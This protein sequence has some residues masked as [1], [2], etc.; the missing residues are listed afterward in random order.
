MSRTSLIFLLSTAALLPLRMA[1]AQGVAL[2]PLPGEEGPVTPTEAF[3]ILPGPGEIPPESLVSPEDTVVEPPPATQDLDQLPDIQPLGMPSD[4]E[5]MPEMPQVPGLVLPKQPAAATGRNL[6][7][8]APGSLPDLLPPADMQLTRKSLWYKSP[9]AARKAAVAE[10]KPL[11]LFFAQL[12]NPVCLTAQ[13]HDDLFILPEFNEFASA[14]L[15]L[16]KLQ[17]PV[18]VP[19]KNSYPEEKLAALKKFQDYFKVTGFPTVVVIDKTGRELERLKG[20]RRL[21]DPG[22]GQ[23][24]STAHGLLDRLK[25][26]VQRHEERRHFRQERLDRLMAK[27]YRQWTSRKGST[28]MGK[29]VQAAPQ[30]IV[31]A[32]EN[33]QFRTVLPAQLILYDAE[34]ARRKQ[35]GLIP[36]P[37]PAERQTAAAEPVR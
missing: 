5:P 34:W 10:D 17:Y 25:E 35:A 9:L 4:G 6:L 16:T 37:A 13:L 22:T 29:L 14:K 24:Y 15:T 26:A 30:R 31:L 3:S 7:P 2:P 12:P 8:G 18:G 28:M 33:G 11:L 23:L 21:A 19:N 1:S 20:Y 32:D 27:G 36:V